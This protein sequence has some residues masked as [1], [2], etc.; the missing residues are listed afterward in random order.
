[1]LSEIRTV[2]VTYP[3]DAKTMSVYTATGAFV[4]KYDLPSNLNYQLSSSSLA[5]GVYILKLQGD[6]YYKSIKISR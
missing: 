6:N 4:G 1:M 5:H 2:L 3:S